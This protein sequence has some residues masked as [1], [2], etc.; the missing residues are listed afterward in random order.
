MVEG[1]L[2]HGVE[3]HWRVA[4]RGTIGWAVLDW[5]LKLL[6]ASNLQ[7]GAVVH[8]GAPQHYVSFQTRWN[9]MQ[10]V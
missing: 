1:I 7:L 4:L 10:T 2:R 6:K 8:T 9:G 3:R 5:M